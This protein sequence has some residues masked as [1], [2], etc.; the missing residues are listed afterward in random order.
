MLFF[1]LNWAIEFEKKLLQ[2]NLQMFE[3]WEDIQ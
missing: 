2:G 1:L 3:F